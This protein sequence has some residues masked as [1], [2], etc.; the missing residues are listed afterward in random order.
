MVALLDSAGLKA[1]KKEGFFGIE[2]YIHANYSSC[3][4]FGSDKDN[5][6]DLASFIDCWNSFILLES[7]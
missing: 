5:S 7:C 3:Y 1:E 6:F 4:S 2:P